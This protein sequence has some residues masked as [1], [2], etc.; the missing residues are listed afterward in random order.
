MKFYYKKFPKKL[1]TLYPI[2]DF[3]FGSAQCNE[4][5]MKQ[6]IA[7]IKDNPNAYW[8]GMGD[9]LENAII[10]SKSDI[11]TQTVPP[12][13]QIEYICD[14]LEPIKEKGLFLIAGNHEQRTMRL[15]G[16]IPEEHIAYRLG[17]SYVGFSCYAV[18]QVASS[19]NPNSFNCY[20][21][22]N[23]G[24]GYTYGGKV[25]R[26]EALRRI[27]PTAD[28]IFSGHFHITSR[29][30]VTWYDVGRKQV[31]KHVGYDYITGSALE[32]DNSYAEERAKPAA[33][34]EF[35]KVTFVGS[36]NGRCDNRKQIYEIIHPEK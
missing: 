36:T 16:L 10:G 34:T 6:T 17:M 30:P 35:I 33:S 7:E 19:K 2:G 28:A 32:W 25:N 5:F 15:V 31:L 13:E 4:D 1:F 9:M 8:V 26:A 22:H 20:F 21:H 14:L 18:F 23:Y 27:T 11:Y 3:H 24:G 12:K 29:I